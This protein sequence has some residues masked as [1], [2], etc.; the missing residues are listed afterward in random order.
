MDRHIDRQ[1]CTR[2]SSSLD[3]FRKQ[4]SHTP[5]T[6]RDDDAAGNAAGCTCAIATEG[7]AGTFRLVIK[8]GAGGGA[9]ATSCCC[10]CGCGCGCCAGGASWFPGGVAAGAALVPACTCTDSGE[11][12]FSAKSR[13][14]STSSHSFSLYRR[15][16]AC[17]RPILYMN[18]PQLLTVLSRKMLICMPV[19]S[20]TADVVR[21][22]CTVLC[23]RMSERTDIG[24]S[25]QQD[26]VC[27][28]SM[29]R[30]TV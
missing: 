27:Q 16:R 1:G 8:S 3:T 2:T 7:G 22:S 11:L 15:L 28:C 30:S 21:H 10:G 14:C 12:P 4:P 29:R 25:A 20:H 6:D 18:I 24:R 17:V 13:R 19:R 9:A 5:R 26:D 23:T